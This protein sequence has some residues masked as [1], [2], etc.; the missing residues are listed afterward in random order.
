V[1]QY[2][3]PESR[4]REALIKRVVAVEVRFKH[5]MTRALC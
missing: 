2:G 1:D 3:Q 5:I 4:G